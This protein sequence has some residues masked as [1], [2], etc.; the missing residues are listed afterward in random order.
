MPGAHARYTICLCSVIIKFN[1]Y[2]KTFK[3]ETRLIE[4][5]LNN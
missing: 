2:I 4:N 3:N 5:G 1:F